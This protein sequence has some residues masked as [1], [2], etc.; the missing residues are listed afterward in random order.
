MTDQST[1]THA[2]ISS[3]IYIHCILPLLE[4]KYVYIYIYI[5]IYIKYI[6]K[7]MVNFQLN[8]IVIVFTVLAN[9]DKFHE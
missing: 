2:H 3:D 4:S 1:H 9:C 5:Y 8:I 6:L 7:V